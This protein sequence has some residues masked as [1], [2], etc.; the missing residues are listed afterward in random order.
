MSESSGKAVGY[1]A[2]GAI[3]EADCEKLFPE[4][5]SLIEKEGTIRILFDMSAFKGFEIR[6]EVEK[7]AF[8]GDKTWIELISHLA[9]P[10]HA[11]DARFFH[12]AGWRRPGLG[13][14]RRLHETS[15]KSIRS[16]HQGC[17]SPKRIYNHN[18]SYFYDIALNMYI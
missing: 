13:L 16:G 1:R 14:K 5:R 12:T 17:Y 3:T 7:M 11:R 8:V 6:H 4:I 9:K 2:A 10:F 18:F 15:S